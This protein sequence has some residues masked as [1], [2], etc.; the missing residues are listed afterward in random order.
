MTRPDIAAIR[1]QY[2]L[3]K[4]NQAELHSDPMHQFEM[5]FQ[6][7]VEAE[8]LEPNAMILATADTDG[9]PKAR[10]VLLKG[11]EVNSNECGFIFYSNYKSNKAKD[12][13]ANPHAALVFNWLDLERQVRVEGNIAKVPQETSAAYFQSRPRGSQLGAW[14]SP[15]SKPI[16]SRKTLDKHLQEIDMRYQNKEIPLPE[17]WGGYL[18][19]PLQ[20]EFWQGRSNRLHD[21]F[22]YTRKTL[23]AT[24]P[25]HMQRLAP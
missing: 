10:V 19:Q 6:D 23:D 4:L 18:V 11:L 21:R 8:L 12:I 16:E 17:F 9:R 1:K 25:W 7:A 14:A 3:K 13:D 20:I 24:S 22:V 2:R 5:W 15:Q